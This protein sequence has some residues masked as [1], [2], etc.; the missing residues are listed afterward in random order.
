[1]SKR[2]VLTVSD[3]ADE[4]SDYLVEFFEPQTIKKRGR[5]IRIP[6][7]VWMELGNMIWLP[8][9][10]YVLFENYDRHCFSI[11]HGD[12]LIDPHP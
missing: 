4:D 2:R 3:N 12:R 7:A 5:T 9:C 8:D 10:K 1:M 6:K 11:L